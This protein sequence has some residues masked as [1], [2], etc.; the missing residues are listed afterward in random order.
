MAR[1]W[2]SK[3]VE[4]Q[5]EEADKHALEPLS[6]AQSTPESRALRVRLESLQL[7]RARTLSQLEVATRPAHRELLQRTLR[8]LEAQIEGLNMEN[9]A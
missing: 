1:G 2:E 3:A 8:A 7:S 6:P 4:A 9:L 5:I